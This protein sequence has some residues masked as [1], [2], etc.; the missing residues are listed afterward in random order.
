MSLAVV[1]DSAGT[2]MKT[3][4]SVIDV[5]T[6]K[7]LEDSVET[8]TLTFQDPDRELV[9]VYTNSKEVMEADSDELFSNY[10][11]KNKIG[12]GISCGRKSMNDDITCRIINSDSNCRISDM[13]KVITSCKEEISK[14]SEVFAMNVGVI[15]N[16]R[17]NEI[18]FGVAAAG[19][20][21][22][23]V[24]K[25]IS[26]L[27]KMGAAVYVAS[28]DRESKL[29]L[30]ADKIGIP[31]DKVHGVATPSVKAKIVSDLKSDHDI[32]MMVGDGINDIEAMKTADVSVLTT[33]QKG[34]KP[35]IL[36]KT[37]DYTINDIRDVVKIAENLKRQA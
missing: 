18:E 37:A 23:G 5:N 17:K 33:Q 19:Y 24:K 9:V 1:F 34:K 36:Y 30:V 12:F 26:D 27:L 15:V 3:V 22:P 2:L 14:E 31:R 6:K 11:S 29:E 16:L 25:T 8:T 10:I 32:V 20:P 35:E 21:F 7:M 13:Q 4:R 28:G